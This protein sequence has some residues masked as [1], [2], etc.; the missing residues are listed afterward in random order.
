MRPDL[1]IAQK[2]TQAKK[3][4]LPVLLS[5]DNEETSEFP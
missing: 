2:S 1:Q 5:T 4:A 3:T